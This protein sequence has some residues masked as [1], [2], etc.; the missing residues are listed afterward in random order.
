ALEGSFVTGHP[1][2]GDQIVFARTRLRIDV[3][4]GGA[5][6]VVWP[7]GK[8]AFNV[9]AAGSRAINVTQDVGLAPGQFGDALVGNI[10]PFLQ[11]DA[12]P[13]AP[14]VGFLGDAVTPHTVTG[15]PFVYSGRPANF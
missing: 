13:P 8:K 4:T 9:A 3:P 10:G 6:T 12:T 14:P 1:Q 5:Y 15:S 7:Y 11:W 2:P